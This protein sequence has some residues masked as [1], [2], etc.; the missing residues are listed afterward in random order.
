MEQHQSREGS[1]DVRLDNVVSLAAYR[2]K[3]KPPEEAA[4]EILFSI[5]DG[6]LHH[7]V[8]HIKPSHVPI[9][10]QAMSEM[11]AKLTA[12]MNAAKTASCIALFLTYLY[13][14]TT[15]WPAMAASPQTPTH[16]TRDLAEG[17]GGNMHKWLAQ[18]ASML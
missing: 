6:D 7:D 9:M 3:H 2:E 1:S 11:S 12:F 5:K 17:R 13:V 16:A 10:L 14:D 4:P 8:K 18:D 15:Y